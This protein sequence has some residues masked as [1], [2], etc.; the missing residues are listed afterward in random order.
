VI[1]GLGRGIE[2]GSSV[3]GLEKLD[4]VIQ[5]DAAINPGNSGGPLLDSSGKVIGVNVATSQSGQNIGFALPISLVKESIDNFKTT[6]EF[7]RAFLGVAY[8]II[9]KQ[10]A[11]L[12]NVPQGAYVQNVVSGSSADKGGIKADDIIT[13]INGKKLS[14]EKDGSLVAFIN[15]MRI[16][17]E[18]NFKVW[19]DKQEI[20]LG[21]KLEKGAMVN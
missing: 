14:D 4:N 10:A 8:K 19:R 15:K 9:S 6:G 1:S 20:S 18:V 13:E 17:D 3:E 11:L 5:T 21:V 12:N 2:A 7:D 16:G